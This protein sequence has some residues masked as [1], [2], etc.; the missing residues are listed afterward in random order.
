MHKSK[1]KSKSKKNYVKGWK[2]EKP[3][4]SEKTIMFN[5]CGNKCFLGPN[6]SFPICT[7]N[8]CDINKKGV[9]SAYMRAREFQTIKGTRKYSE[10]AKKADSILRKI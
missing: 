7:K 1:S 10:I 9:Y 4:Q 3:N 2:N 6:K 8:T 5:N